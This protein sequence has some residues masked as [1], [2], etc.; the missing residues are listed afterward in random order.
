MFRIIL[1][2]ESLISIYNP[3]TKELFSVEECPRTKSV[4]WI[5]RC[6]RAENVSQHPK[7]KPAVPLVTTYLDSKS[8]SIPT[9]S[10]VKMLLQSLFNVD[11]CDKDHPINFC[12]NFDELKHY[13][14][15]YDHYGVQINNNMAAAKMQ[16]M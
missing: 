15:R 5:R 13:N 12:T 7:A 1:N 3:K 11:L 10:H 16:I 4:S 14:L 9:D 8:K 6:C 2:K